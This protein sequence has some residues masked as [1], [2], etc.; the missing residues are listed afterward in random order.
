[1]KIVAAPIGSAS[2]SIQVYSWFNGRF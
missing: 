2:G 1:M